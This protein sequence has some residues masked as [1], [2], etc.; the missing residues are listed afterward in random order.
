MIRKIVG[1]AIFVAKHLH[2]LIHSHTKYMYYFSV[3]IK[4]YNAQICNK[5]IHAFE[6][7][8]FQKVRKIKKKK[9]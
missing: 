6:Y 1:V 5:C 4:Y 3:A 2:D 7:K 8:Y 9:T